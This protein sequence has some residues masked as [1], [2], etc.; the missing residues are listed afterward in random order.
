MK[1]FVLFLACAAALMGRAADAPTDATFADLAV[2]EKRLAA[3]QAILDHSRGFPVASPEA[4]AWFERV[5]AAAKS[6]EHP[7]AQA[8]LQQILLFE[9]NAKPRLPLNPR[10]PNTY[11]DPVGTTPE[12]KLAH[13]ERVLD[14][15][16]SAKEYPLTV[17]ELVALTKHEDFATAQRA[18]R[19]LRRVSSAT[20]APILWERLGKL[21][22]RSQVQE[23]EDEILR[24][25]VSLAAKHVPTELAG[26]SLAAKAAWARI[27]AV[28]GSRVGGKSRPALKTTVLPLLKGPANEL[29]E[30]AWA[31][32]PRLFAEADRA[33]LTEAAQGLSERLAPKAKAALDALPAK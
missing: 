3:Q 24:L 28:R 1:T 21:T 30:A 22:Q 17:D 12:T 15:R 26:A 32:V 16:R 7:E 13:L 10:Q 9:P 29:T 23:V 25:P 5:R 27:V 20:A 31:I 33:V 14:Q 18:N 6:V 19:L 2:P 8:A 4:K 11:E